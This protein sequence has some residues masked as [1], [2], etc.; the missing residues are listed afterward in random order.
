MVSE[1]KLFLSERCY[2]IYY[3]NGKR[4]REYTGKKLGLNINPSK[5]K[6]YKERLKHLLKLSLEIQKAIENGWHPETIKEVVIPI[7]VPTTL[8][9]F[10]DI[11]N[12]KKNSDFSNS[13]KRDLSRTCEQFLEF[14]PPSIL[15][16]P[17]TQINQG[18]I[19]AFLSQ[20]TS[21][22]TYFMNKR[23]ALN[24]F[25]SELLRTK[26]IQENIVQC[27]LR[28]KQK[29]VLHK[30]YT[31]E[32]LNKILEY[33]K[34]NH[35]NLHLCALLIYGCFLRPHQ[36]ARLLCLKHLN[37]DLS[38]ITLSGSE[39]KSKRIRVVNIP[40]YVQT[41]LKERI[42]GLEN[43]DTNIISKSVNPYNVCYLNTQWSRAKKNMLK[44]GLIE[45]DQTLYSFRH[46]A[47]VNV[48][49]KTKDLHILQQLLQH[50]NMIVTLNYLRG[51]GEINDERLRDV[52]PEL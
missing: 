8:E 35:P 28:K 31:K 38:K 33:L 25:F 37:D 48:Y 13:Y 12:G 43:V 52:L 47:V 27:T 10:T 51:L 1:P 20:F 9:A 21:S 11:L 4:Y 40:I 3:I 50:S 42:D 2:V 30:I 44:L 39:N 36:E 22:S 14:L 26:Q 19:E 29:A 45:K 5:C 49:K 16:S 7:T 46:T 6:T 17:P 23:R 18:Q 32:Q 41:I 24:V 15:N 34:V